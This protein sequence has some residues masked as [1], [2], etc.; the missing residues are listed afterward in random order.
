MNDHLYNKE[1]KQRVLSYELLKE[2]KKEGGGEGEGKEGG[3]KK[4]EKKEKDL[5]IEKEKEK[6]PFFDEVC[7]ICLGEDQVRDVSEDYLCLHGWRYTGPSWTFMTKEFP[8][9]AG[10]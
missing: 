10:R 6:N 5:V 9:W 1:C 3:E 4:E 8:W 2:G 7:P